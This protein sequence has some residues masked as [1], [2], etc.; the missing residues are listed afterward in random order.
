MSVYDSKANYHPVS[1]LP[2]SLPNGRRVHLDH[3][4]PSIDH[5]FSVGSYLLPGNGYYRYKWSIDHWIDISVLSLSL[6]RS[7]EGRL[8]RLRYDTQKFLNDPKYTY[9][10]SYRIDAMQALRN[11][12]KGEEKRRDG[13]QSEWSLSCVCRHQF[14]SILFLLS[15][16][17][18]G[19][20]TTYLCTE[21]FSQWKSLDLRTQRSE[22]LPRC[23]SMFVFSRT[24][25]SFSFLSF[26]WHRIRVVMLCVVSI[27]YPPWIMS[28]YPNLTT[29]MMFIVVINR[30]CPSK[31]YQSVSSERIWLIS[32]L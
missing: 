5:C 11:A 2:G 1:T 17:W 20:R 12:K 31:P 14:T 18:S 8:P 21:I 13:I 6:S 29:I 26:S 9:S 32:H 16:F 7:V 24:F 27:H 10:Q 19:T 23:R 25:L 15:A 30:K 3:L 28:L 22:I 4:S